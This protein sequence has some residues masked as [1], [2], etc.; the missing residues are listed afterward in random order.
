ME[1]AAN[2]GESKSV[3]R[4]D[5]VCF[6]YSSVERQNA[7]SEEFGALLGVNDWHEM[8]SPSRKLRVL[9]SWNGGI[10]LIA[11][12]EPNSYLDNH[13]ARHGE[14]FYSFAFGVENLDDAVESLE[15]Q[16]RT[17]ARTE[18][19]PES[20]ARFAVARQ[21]VIGGPVGGHKVIISEFKKK[22]GE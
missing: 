4:V 9:M 1:S 5:H 11:P 15:A 14:G 16:G 19:H 7:A 2:I 18:G 22:P 17:A 10:E 21:A 12:T 13:L 3:G 8:E 6:I 20:R